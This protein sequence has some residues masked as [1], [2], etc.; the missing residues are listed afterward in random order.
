MLRFHRYHNDLTTIYILIFG[1]PMF[2]SITKTPYSPL[3]YA[4]SL[5]EHPSSFK[6]RP[7]SACHLSCIIKSAS[8]SRQNEKKSFQNVRN[9]LYPILILQRRPDLVGELARDL[10]RVHAGHISVQALPLCDPRLGR[11]GQRYQALKDLRRAA[12]DLVLRADEVQE[13][14]AVGASFVAEAL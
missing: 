13:F 11:V 14:L 2:D 9:I 12:F 1:P 4:K 10:D 3:L 5:C 6:H 8:Q 7:R